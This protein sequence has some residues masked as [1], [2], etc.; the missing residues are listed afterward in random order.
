MAGGDL[1]EIHAVTV[2][3]ED[4]ALVLSGRA[5][6]SISQFR[7]KALADLSKKMSRCK[8]GSREKVQRR[9]KSPTPNKQ[10]PT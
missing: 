6:R 1:G 9:Q 5:M 10:Q 3:T 4:R 2:A 8:K 7:A